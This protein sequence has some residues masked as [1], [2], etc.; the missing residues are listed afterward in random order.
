MDLRVH[1]GKAWCVSQES[2]L[3]ARCQSCK[4]MRKLKG[5]GPASYPGQQQESFRGEPQAHG[6]DNEE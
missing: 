3:L 4:N 2:H 6:S 5:T 1:G